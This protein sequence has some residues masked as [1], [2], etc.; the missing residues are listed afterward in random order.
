MRSVSAAFEAAIGLGVVRMCEL[1]VVTLANGDIYRYTDHA[2]DV[3]WDAAGNTYTAIPIARSPIRFNSDGRYDECEMTLGIQG[4]EFLDKIH[5]NIMEASTIIHKRIR[6]DTAFAADEE[7][8]LNIWQPDINFNRSALALRLISRM[9][10]LGIKVPNHTYQEPCNNFLFDDTCGLIRADF[11]YAGTA[12][13]GTAISLTDASAGTLYT[14]DFDAGDSGNP[15]AKGETITG[16]DNGY[17][18][19]VV[20]IVYLT[21]TTGTIWYV[22]LSN[23]ANYNNNEVLTSGG[24]TVDVAGTPAEDTKFYEQGEIEMTGGDNSGESRPILTTSGS[25]RTAMWPFVSDIA[26]GDT[27]NIYPGDDFRPVTC[28]KRYNNKDN[29][30]GFPYGPPVENILL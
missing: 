17:T 26:G 22:E 13:A 8:I 25:L 6:W 4:I 30:R 2:E 27:Y 5:G 19:V 9:D 23:A 20:Q 18:A 21:A 1:Y 29:W 14:V 11:A 7:I 28:D 10:S 3:V 16:G 12:T 15:I 24:D